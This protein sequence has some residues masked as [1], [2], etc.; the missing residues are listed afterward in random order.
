MIQYGQNFRKL[1]PAKRSLG[2]VS[3]H[4][5]YAV[6]A[7]LFSHLRVNH[8]GYFVDVDRFHFSVQPEA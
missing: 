2:S 8:I 7:T 1:R 5:L 4:D 3:K 6:A